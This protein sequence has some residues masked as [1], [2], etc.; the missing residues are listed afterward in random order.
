MGQSETWVVVVHRQGSPV[1]VLG[2]RPS[3]VDAKVLSD[4]VRLRSDEQATVMRLR[5]PDSADLRGERSDPGMGQ[6]VRWKPP[7][8]VGP[9]LAAGLQ[10]RASSAIPLLRT[11]DAGPLPMVRAAPTRRQPLMGQSVCSPEPTEMRRSW[12]DT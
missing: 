6:S 11:H 7:L 2:T 8:V 9:E 1:A 5:E 12:S 3:A 4:V 10:I